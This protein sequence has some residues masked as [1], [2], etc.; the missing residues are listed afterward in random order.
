MQLK[1]I[2]QNYFG[3]YC[4]EDD[5]ELEEELVDQPTADAPAAVIPVTTVA[6]A[7]ACIERVLQAVHSNLSRLLTEDNL[8]LHLLEVARHHLAGRDEAAELQVQLHDR[9]CSW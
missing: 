2:T 4:A 1:S 3:C 6:A 9:G 5:Q 8:Q 7:S